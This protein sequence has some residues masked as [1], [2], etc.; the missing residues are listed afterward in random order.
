MRLHSKTSWDSAR[1]RSA[2]V[3]GDLAIPNGK[4]GFFSKHIRRLSGS[5]PQF[6][7]GYQHPQVEKAKYG[8][9]FGTLS[10]LLHRARR[11]LG[12]TAMIVIAIFLFWMSRKF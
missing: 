6:V 2:Q 10:K 11:Q 7:N 9:S 5:L 3:N 12:I 8:S 1:A 4:N